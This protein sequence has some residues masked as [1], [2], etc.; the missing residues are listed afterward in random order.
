MRL[1][2]VQS[3]GVKTQ[4][5][6]VRIDDAEDE[7]RSKDKEEP[8]DGIADDAPRLFG[9]R[10]AVAA[11]IHDAGT[12]KLDDGENDCRT[13][14]EHVKCIEEGREVVRLHGIGKPGDRRE[15]DELGLS[16]GKNGE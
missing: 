2:Y 3:T 16:E 6:D 12:D 9:F 15:R 8:E 4:V 1:I 10:D 5:Q 11:H 13:D 7:S 14:G